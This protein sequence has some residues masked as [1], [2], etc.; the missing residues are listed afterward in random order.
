MRAVDTGVLV[1]AAS[2]W[3]EAHEA[4]RRELTAGPRVAAHTMVETYSVLT[5][6]PGVH[7]VPRDLAAEFIERA[8]REEPL[9]LDAAELQRLVTRRLPALG[10][11]GGAVYDALIAETVRLA[12]GTLVTLDR[13]ALTTYE[14]IGCAAELL[15]AGG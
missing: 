6:L 14:R 3:H 10:I 11:A 7:R 5:R 12:G 1:A 9:T 15:S 2:S 8:I 13:R 4:A